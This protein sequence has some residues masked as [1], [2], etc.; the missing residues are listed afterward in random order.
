MTQLS[1]NGYTDDTCDRDCNEQPDLSI[2]SP[3]KKIR[4]SLQH[5]SPVEAIYLKSAKPSTAVRCPKKGLTAAALRAAAGIPHTSSG[6]PP[7]GMDA[8]SSSYS[9]MGRTTT[10][11]ITD[12]SPPV[13][14]LVSV[15]HARV[16]EWVGPTFFGVFG[17]HSGQ[18]F[19]RN[20][21]YLRRANLPPRRPLGLLPALRYADPQ[22]SR[23]VR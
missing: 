2:H 10:S 12:V 13:L 6:T 16:A 22:I 9:C 3:I 17:L 18:D 19:A 4:L 7:V 1:S 8:F 23:R 5:T 20:D 14:L 15:F 21:Q 11:L